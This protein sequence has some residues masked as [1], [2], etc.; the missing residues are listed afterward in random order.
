[1]CSRWNSG[2]CY[3]ATLR[4]SS[5]RSNCITAWNWRHVAII[6]IRCH[7]NGRVDIVRRRGWLARWREKR[8]RYASGRAQVNADQASTVSRRQTFSDLPAGWMG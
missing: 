7:Q 2:Y 4:C 3:K 1:M 6:S 8:A 5:R